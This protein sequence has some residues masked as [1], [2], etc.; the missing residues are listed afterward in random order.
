M[1]LKTAAGA[2]TDPDSFQLF[3]RLHDHQQPHG[4]GHDLLSVSTG[5][6]AAPGTYS[7]KVTNLAQSR[8]YP[9]IPSPAGPRNWAVAYGDLVINGRVVTI[10]T[11]DTLVGVANSINN[12]NSGSNP[13]RVTASVVNF[14]AN[15]FRL[16]LT[17]DTTGAAGSASERIGQ[18]PGAIVWLERQSD[19]HHKKSHHLRGPEHRFTS[20][21]T[22]IG[23]LMGL[24]VSAS[25]NV[26]I[27]NQNVAINLSTMSLTDIKNAINTAAPTGV[28]ASVIRRRWKA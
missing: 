6:G 14:G 1:S 16:V 19:G 21:S 15:D 27:G 2:L 12:L 20:A 22:A 8:N 11:T 26:T 7:I 13:S 23:S 9:P 17:S 18:Q 10:K 5:A 3:S 4:E 28:S 25:A 24:S